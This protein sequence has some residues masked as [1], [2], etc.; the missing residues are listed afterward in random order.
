LEERLI[1]LVSAHGPRNFSRIAHDLNVSRKT[2]VAAYERLSEEGL[3]PRPNIKM[4]KLGLQRYAA[5]A[6]PGS[7]SNPTQLASV[8]ATMGD[9]AYLEHYQKLDPSNAYLLYFSCP[10]DLVQELNT[11]LSKMERDSIFS[12]VGPVAL[13]WMRYHPIRAPWNPTPTSPLISGPLD[14][15]PKKE[16]GARAA[17]LEYGELLLLAALQAF[18]NANLAGLSSAL[19]K[20][21]DA[22]YEDVKSY[23]LTSNSDWNTHLQKALRYVES[24][25]VHRSR[26]EPGVTRRRRHH[27][28]SFTLLWDQLSRDDIKRAAWASTSIPYLRTDAASE[29]SGLYFSVIS[30]PS[31]LIPG[32][33]SFVSRNAPEKMN[34]GIP[35]HFANYS[36][37]FA[38]YMPADGRWAWK[39]ERLETVLA[40]LQAE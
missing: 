2:A 39:Q 14:Y 7:N 38:A 9:Y 6:R 22:G 30:A 29:E 28:A 1:R 40:T 17:N 11:F 15:I 20:W 27:W 4:S 33:I 19:S 13:D 8:F 16:T 25:P 24:F 32:Y 21:A 3:G 35:S 34:V 18:P 31:N 36:L 12:I 5:V 10:P 26:G 37:P 23:S